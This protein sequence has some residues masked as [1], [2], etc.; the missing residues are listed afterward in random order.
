[1]PWSRLAESGAIPQV[2]FLEKVVVPVVCNDICPVQACSNRRDA[3]GAVPR[4]SCGHARRCAATGAGI[5]VQKT[6]ELPQLQLIYMVGHTLSWRRVYPHG[7]SVQETFE[8]PL[9]QYAWR[10]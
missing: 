2:Q 10:W 3:A 1:M 9:L 8:F 7:Y 4:Q 5:D 6:A